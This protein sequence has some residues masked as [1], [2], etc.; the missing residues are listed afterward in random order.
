MLP[1][2][3][4]GTGVRLFVFSIGMDF[5]GARSNHNLLSPVGGALSLTPGD[6]RNGR[7]GDSKPRPSLIIYSSHHKKKNNNTA[8]RPSPSTAA[9]KLLHHCIHPPPPPPPPLPLSTNLLGHHQS[10]SSSRRINERRGRCRRHR[11]T[12]VRARS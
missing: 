2:S 4:L 6:D 8:A 1:F 10:P 3:F 5:P 11:H 9:T 12:C 7:W